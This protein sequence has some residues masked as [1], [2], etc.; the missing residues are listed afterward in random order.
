[1]TVN[2]LDFTHVRR[3]LIVKLSSFGDIVHVTPCLRA[4]RQAAPSAE[5]I[6]AV[7][8][9]FSA[10]VRNNPHL[11]RMIESDD[12]WIGSI[13]DLFRILRELAPFR[14]APFDVAIDFQGTR[15]S[16]MWVY[17]SRA[18]FKA[19]RGKTRPGWARA[20]QPDMNQHSIRVCA[21]IAEMIG[22]PVVDLQPEIVVSDTD[23][24]VLLAILDDQG[25]PE[26]GFVILNPFSRWQSKTW[27]S[28]R[29]A[30]VAAQLR[31]EFQIPIV[32]TGGPD[33]G[34]QA[35][36]LLR[37]LQPGTAIS[38]VGRLTLGQALCLYRRAVLM[39]TGD[40]G[41][42]H[43]AAALGIRIVALFGPT[44]PQRSG[45]WGED[46]AVI[47]AMRPSFHH[48]YRTDT[49]G[50]YMRAIDVPTVYAAIRSALQSIL[51]ER[52]QRAASAR[53]LRPADVV[54]GVT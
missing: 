34:Q 13:P 27:P 50:T 12:R 25:V 22:I 21:R 4:V 17:A 39:L 32:I 36:E 38:L 10:V 37:V 24:R 7:D 20:L 33:E 14:H 49:E 1:M 40:T 15:R 31:R 48:A 47:Q 6:M 16:A 28:D 3:I 30:Q 46:H 35:E 26:E 53:A 2:R 29:Y 19:G 9:R 52:R 44:M 43:A 41:P 51:S 11:D 18:R 8:R 45:P 42:M 54:Q 23:D 5:I